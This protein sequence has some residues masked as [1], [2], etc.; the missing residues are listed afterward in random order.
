MNSSQYKALLVVVTLL[1]VAGFSTAGYIAYT[2][3]AASSS[4][5]GST[6]AF[7]SA[8]IKN[9]T[10]E[11]Q[12]T[13]YAPYTPA[14]V[15]ALASAFQ[16]A[17]PKITVNGIPYD[18]ATLLNKWSSEVSSGKGIADIIIGGAT[19]TY[20][21]GLQTH[22]EMFFPSPEYQYYPYI[23]YG[24]DN[25]WWGPTPIVQVFAYNTNE[26]KGSQIP[27]GFSDLAAK[28]QANPAFWNGKIAVVDP[29]QDFASF[30]VL[31]SWLDRYGNSTFWNWIATYAKDGMVAV[32]SDGALLQGIASGQYLVGFAPYFGDVFSYI[33]QGAP[34]GIIYP[35]EGAVVGVGGFAISS[36]APHPYAAELF[37]NWLLS[38][39]GQLALAK[40]A[41]AFISFRTDISS[42]D[43]AAVVGFTPPTFSYSSSN[44]W[45]PLLNGTQVT[46]LPETPLQQQA[47]IGYQSE[48]A[49]QF[50]QA[51]TG[52]PP[53]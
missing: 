5:G 37:M 27:T 6:S 30:A 2:A 9:A 35:S 14:Q 16:Q 41:G 25:G 31:Y 10:A 34:V 38:K 45:P 43:M 23:P 52:T 48:F 24:T 15:Q 39:A 22:S 29:R 33:E 7:L 12:V 44:A 50:T 42:S 21:A 32:S 18:T 4:S 36:V 20:Y 17:Y 46:P 19:A 53:S 11:G 28:V 47:M 26:L 13:V 8:L 1:A 40:D 51:M 3:P 49:S